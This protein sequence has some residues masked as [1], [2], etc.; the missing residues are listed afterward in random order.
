MTTYAQLM[1]SSDVFDT[2]PILSRVAGEIADVQVRN[3]GTIGGNVCLS[4]PTNHFPP[5]MVAHGRDASRSPGRTAS[6]RCPPTSSS[7]AST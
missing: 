4:D 6:A 3:R 7:S 2:R 5:L 1:D